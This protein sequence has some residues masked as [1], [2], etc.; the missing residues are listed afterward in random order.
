[1]GRTLEEAQENART[2]LQLW[3][4][5][6]KEQGLPMPKASI[7]V[8]AF[9]SGR[10]GGERVQESDGLVADKSGDEAAAGGGDTA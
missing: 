4:E 8:L 7:K 3:V 2:G 9:R 1:M 10:L 5:D 6:M